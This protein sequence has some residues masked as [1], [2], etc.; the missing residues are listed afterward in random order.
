[1]KASMKLSKTA[2]YLCLIFAAGLAVAQQQPARPAPSLAKPADNDAKPAATVAPEAVVITVGAEKITRAQFEQILAALAENGRAATTPAAKRQLADQV[3]EIIGLAQEA[4]KRKLDQA[5]G[6][7]QMIMIS[8]DQVLANMLGNRVASELKIDDAGLHA[9]Y[10]AHKAD[11]EQAKAIHILIRFKGSRVPIK[12]GGK[13]L[14]EE[15]AL[16]KAQ[17]IRKQLLAGGD[18][19][20]IAKAESDDTVSAADGGSLG[21]ASGRGKFVPPFDQAVFSLPIGQVSEPVKTPFGY[22]LIKVESRGAKPFEEAKPDIEK[23]M[24]PQMVREAMDK[25]KKDTPV[26]LDDSYFGQ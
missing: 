23:K 17:D 19:A 3:G 14:S 13:D 15:E 16:A 10:D 25:V 6:V 9:Y 8:S 20:T 18:F 26:T 7:Q 5:P 24:K 2:R 21:P 11:F 1:M 22:H 4:R 12:P